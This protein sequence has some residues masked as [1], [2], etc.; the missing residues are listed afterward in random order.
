MLVGS[1]QVRCNGPE[2]QMLS[3][4]SS[5]WLFLATSHKRGSVQANTLNIAKPGCI[6][7]LHARDRAHLLMHP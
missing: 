7:R 5:R 2:F 6:V 3:H 4:S 1:D